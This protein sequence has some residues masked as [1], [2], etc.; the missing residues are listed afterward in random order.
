MKNA[1]EERIRL[2]KNFIKKYPNADL[3]KFDFQVYL[4]Q[5][6]TVDSTSIYFKDSDVLS[7]DIASDTFLNDKTMTRYLY[8]KTSRSGFPKN[9]QLVEKFRNYQKAG[10]MLVFMEK[11][12][13]G[14]ISLLIIFYLTP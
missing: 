12:T 4:N 9:G 6:C 8:S 10:D 11:N 2:R 5:D 13:T 1:E 14:I 3:S 7:T